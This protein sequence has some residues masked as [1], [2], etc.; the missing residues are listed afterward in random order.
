MAKL[1]EIIGL[2]YIDMVDITAWALCLVIFGV[3]MGKCLYDLFGCFGEIMV[4]LFGYL[5][6]FVIKHFPNV[7]KRKGEQDE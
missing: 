1:V 5:F 7:R 3:A 4:S 6:S 2:S